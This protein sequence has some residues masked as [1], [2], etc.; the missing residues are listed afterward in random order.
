MAAITE[1]HTQKTLCH[2]KVWDQMTSI[3]W[4]PNNCDRRWPV[5]CMV[6][7]TI[8]TRSTVPICPCSVS[9]LLPR[10]LENDWR[11]DMCRTKPNIAWCTPAAR[12]D[13]DI[14]WY[15]P[16]SLRVDEGNQPQL[17]SQKI[18]NHT[19]NA[20][21]VFPRE[22]LA[23]PQ[24]TFGTGKCVSRENLAIPPQKRHAPRWTTHPNQ[25]SSAPIF[26]KCRGFKSRPRQL[27]VAPTSSGSGNLSGWRDCRCYN[28]S[29]L[30]FS[31][32][33]SHCEFRGVKD[34]CFCKKV[35]H[36]GAS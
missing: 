15:T 10:S 6:G 32:F 34:R 1:L 19:E 5:K 21:I 17:T 29:S 35:I 9:H 3:K 25:S 14:A 23:I 18:F 16:P 31:V 30:F 4:L 28:P 22:H 2:R 24:T 27:V 11:R 12:L 7:Y 8:A 36:P 20:G 33:P 26:I 13:L